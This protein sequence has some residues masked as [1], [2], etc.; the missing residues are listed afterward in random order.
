MCTSQTALRAILTTGFLSLERRANRQSSCWLE[1]GLLTHEGSFAKHVKDAFV[2]LG[3]PAE[4]QQ[5]TFSMPSS[6]V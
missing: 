6:T 5:F 4:S 2:S 3:L 1:N